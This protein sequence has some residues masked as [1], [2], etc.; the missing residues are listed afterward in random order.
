MDAYTAKVDQKL[1]SLITRCSL[2]EIEYHGLSA[3]LNTNSPSG[4]EDNEASYEMTVQTR[5][6]DQE[7]GVQSDLL[8]ESARGTVEVSAVAEYSFTGEPPDEEVLGKFTA[9]IA[10]LTLF[11]YLRQAVSDMSHRVFGEAVTLPIL[12]LE[13]IQLRPVLPH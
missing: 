5:L 3:K 7:F 10:I 11:P 1:H 13:D 4:V 12:Q 9:E 6:G 8:M 2:S